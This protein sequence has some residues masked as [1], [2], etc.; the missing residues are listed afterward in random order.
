MSIRWPAFA[1]AAALILVGCGAG[2]LGDPGSGAG[3]GPEV[4]VTTSILG[5]VVGNVLGDVGELH[6]LMPAGVDPHAFEPSAAEAARIREAD[7][8]IVNGLQLEVGLI[9]T[10][11]SAEDDGVPV[12]RVADE[13]DPID[14]EGDLAHADEGDENGNEHGEEA[15]DPHVWFDPV[16]MA[17]AV[18]L[19]GERLAEVAPGS[20]E[21]VRGN[22]ERYRQELLDLHDRVAEILGGIPDGSRE[23]VT[24]H[25]SLGYLAARYDLELVGTVV[26][27]GTTL[28]E[29]SSRE[30][31]EL[32]EKVRE[33]DVP[34]IF[35]ETTAPD[36]L[37][38]TVSAELGGE[39][40]VVELYTGALGP[41]G[42]GADTYVGLIETDARRI[43]DALTR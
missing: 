30:I 25:D 9:D 43:A 4:V 34:A 19:L 7:L 8:V 15:L 40:E 17:D 1:L 12:V 6:V 3:S 18:T 2:P 27:G 32:I 22:A 42:S 10:L 11:R 20:A 37:A 13:L 16:R 23:L 28:G 39:I 41:E 29:A 35:V 21:Q 26:P 38:R 31:A 36:R 14:F 33:A 24:N 5:D